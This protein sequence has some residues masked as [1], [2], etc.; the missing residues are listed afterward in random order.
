MNATDVQ[1]GSAG[2]LAPR[3]TCFVCDSP[4]LKPLHEEVF[5]LGL[6]LNDVYAGPIL[7]PYEGKRFTLNCCRDCGFI[8]AEGIPADPNYF[9]ALYSQQWSEEWM[10]SDFESTYKDNIFRG[11]LEE[12]G[13][14]I[15]GTAKKLLDVGT[16]VGKMIYLAGQAGWE[17]DGIE[18]NPLTR[19]I[20]IRKTGRP[21]HRMTA[22]ELARSGVKYDA[23]T[24]TD[25]LE[26]I[27]DP[28]SILTDLRSMLKPG[29]IIAI[30]VPSGMNQLRKEKL[31]VLLGV[32]KKAEI[33]T[34]FIHVNHFSPTALKLALTRAGFV[35]PRVTV[36]APELPPGGGLRGA[37]SR[38]F[39]IL[40]Y[41]FATLPG[42]VHSP[43]G[44]NL[45]AYAS[46]PS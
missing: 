3:T 14:P 39:R 2:L 46:V 5:R 11:I 23:I 30:K 42:G 33:G 4:R 17:A 12:I 36:G 9:D 37:L 18:L 31:R 7:A 45:Q 25:V 34:N 8:Q 22:K 43:L 1:H 20:A 32:A 10:L 13:R 28:V 24:I 16:H 21:V 29:G 6:S 15:H 26:H 27:P 19:D 40:V 41:R 38:S 44:L 35:N